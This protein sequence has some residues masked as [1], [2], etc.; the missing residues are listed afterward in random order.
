MN[1]GCALDLSRI[2]TG[3]PRLRLD[4]NVILAWRGVSQTHA[5]DTNAT[6]VC[7]KTL[8]HKIINSEGQAFRVPNQGLESNFCLWIAGQRFTSKDC[9]FT[10]TGRTSR[11]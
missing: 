8:L 1:I 7:P 9:F 10:D 3:L 11:L 2:Q 5:R 6:G 4:L